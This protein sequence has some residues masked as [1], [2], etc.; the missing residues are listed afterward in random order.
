MIHLDDINLDILRLLLEDGR[1]SYKEIGKRIGLT[2][3]AVTER[4]RKLEER[5]VITGYRALVDYSALGLPLLCIIRLNSSQGSREVDELLASLPEVTEAHRVTGSE[6]HVIRAR[7]RDTAHLEDLLHRFW[8]H[9]NSIT[10]IVTSSPVPRRPV[11]MGEIPPA[12]DTDSNLPAK[13]R[14]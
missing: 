10:N 12:P 11:D 8:D 5:G 9:G 3:P 6:S 2:A 14:R 7:V 4:I 1:M 13:R